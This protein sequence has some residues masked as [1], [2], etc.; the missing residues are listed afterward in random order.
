MK[1]NKYIK[2]MKADASFFISVLILFYYKAV[3]KVNVKQEQV[4]L[5]S[6]GC[7]LRS[8]KFLKI[9]DMFTSLVYLLSLTPLS[10]HLCLSWLSVF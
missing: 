6:K 7:G 3:G 1:F 5:I 4:R 9:F 2:G 10:A 8:D